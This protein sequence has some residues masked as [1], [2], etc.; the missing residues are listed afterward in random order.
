[1]TS[2][3]SAAPQWWPMVQSAARA[4][5]E[6]VRSQRPAFFAAGAD[7]ALQPVAS[8]DPNAVLAWN[9]EQ[10]WERLSPPNTLTPELI[11]LYLPVCSAHGGNPIVIG[12]LGQSL[13]GFIATRSGDSHYVT[14]PENIV[15]LHRMRALCDAVIVG[16]GTVAADDPQLTT[17]LVRGSNPL[18]VIIDPRCRLPTSHR[19]FSD[20]AARTVRVCAAGTKDFESS[21]SPE[22]SLMEVRGSADQLDLADL[23]AKLHAMG[24]SRIFIE[25]GGR[26]VSAFLQAGL[27]D[28][29]QI[30]VTCLLIGEGRPAIR[31]PAP[32][33]LAECMRPAQRVFRLGNDVLFE[34][35]LRRNSPSTAATTPRNP[36]DRR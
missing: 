8:D 20:G 6:L 26:T 21:R 35:D 22:N 11:D 16:A 14:G 24:L 2:T 17:R 5:D 23:L 10:G 28:R 34:C 4:V 27:L 25:G 33:R 19:V 9:P 13:D 1:M 32:Q 7:G 36:D 12:H 31:L 3:H 18:R 29:L 30:T 15:H